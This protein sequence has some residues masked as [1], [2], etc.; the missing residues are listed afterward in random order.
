[1]SPLIPAA[2]RAP[3]TAPAV[4]GAQRAPTPSGDDFARALRRESADQS[5]L[6]SRPSTR[7]GDDRSDAAREM[8]IETRRADQ[9]RTAADAAAAGSAAARRPVVRAEGADRATRG[10][11]PD[12]PDATSA[13]A[14]PGVL[15]ADQNAAEAIDGASAPVTLS[16]PSV[17]TVLL[18]GASAL[19]GEAVG[20]SATA[21]ETVVGE[22]AG[23]DQ[24][25]VPSAVVGAAPVAAPSGAHGE[26]LLGPALSASGSPAGAVAPAQP[27][28][29]VAPGQHLADLEPTNVAPQEVPASGQT[30]AAAAPGPGEGVVAVP[31]PGQP[32]TAAISGSTPAALP[33]V[34]PGPA[35]SSQGDGA[36]DAGA[37]GAGRTPVADG[38]A[39]A[40]GPAPTAL[41]GTFAH[42]LAGLT[43][44]DR[45]S[46]S[47][48]GSTA[49]ATLAEQVRG[50]VLALRS[51]APGE[52]VLTLKVTP[53]NLGPVQVRA[54]IGAEGIRIELVGA[55][56][57]A[58]EG[59]R[60]L[61]TDLRRDLAGTGMNASL[62]LGA[63]SGTGGRAG[64]GATGDLSSA[65][66]GSGQ[67]RSGR[68][69]DS[70]VTREP[71]TAPAVPLN[72]TSSGAHGVDILT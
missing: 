19:G 8:R 71:L 70:A 33:A 34:V 60:S 64:H 1:M 17:A 42:T 47:A 52:H 35:I 10:G 62:S 67:S 65:G 40:A 2:L 39:P 24:R 57:A 58:R 69:S 27:A 20:G 59:L 11:G 72:P 29:A 32:G 55:T 36:T 49:Q 53:E 16:G 63:D 21:G 6:T 54:H 50:P 14:G 30:T 45:V 41:P 28:T 5:A 43:G 66:D 44:V 3:Q 22:A 18:A 4:Q 51:A 7:P 68:S 61:L 12:G 26:S 9:R 37:G 15:P 23:P 38:A 13:A 56:D 46:A 25:L 31:A 48:A